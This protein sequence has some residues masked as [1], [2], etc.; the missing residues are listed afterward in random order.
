[1]TIAEQL[2][3][4]RKELGLSQEYVAD[5]VGLSRRALA[6]YEAGERIPNAEVLFLLCNFY[7]IDIKNLVEYKNVS[8]ANSQNPHFRH[9]DIDVWKEIIDVF[10]MRVSCL[11]G[12]VKVMSYEQYIDTAQPYDIFMCEQVLADD[13][14]VFIIS[15]FPEF[16]VDYFGMKLWRTCVKHT[17]NQLAIYNCK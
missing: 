2:K 12:N 3:K 6:Y 17:K 9:Y 7:A 4:K 16:L 5:K 1:M 11:L 10:S 15:A 13:N 14:K 8:S